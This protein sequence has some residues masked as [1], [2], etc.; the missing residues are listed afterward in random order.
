MN[1]QATRN[2]QYRLALFTTLLAFCVVLMGAYVRLSDAG[3]GCPDWPGCYGSLLVPEHT[4][5]VVPADNRHAKPLHRGKA[6][7]A[8]PGTLPAR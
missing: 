3:L 2:R 1:L 6:V 5:A 7:Y 8:T 4:T